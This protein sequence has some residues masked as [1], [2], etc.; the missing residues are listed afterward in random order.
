VWAFVRTGGVWAQRGPKLTP[1][2]ESG[3]GRF[4]GAVAVSANGDTLLVGGHGDAG[5]R[6]AAWAFVAAAG[7]WTQQGP[8]LIAP[9]ETPDGQFGG[10]VALSAAGTTAVISAWN[11]AGGAGTAWVYVRTGQAWAAAARLTPRD[12]TGPGAF[13]A[14][15]AISADGGIVL[16]GGPQDKGGVGGAWLF[17]R[18]GTE[19]QQVAP[20]LRPAGETGTGAFGLSVAL[21][22]D[23]ATA[24][25]GAG[26]DDQG[27]G[28][29]WIFA[30]AGTG[31]TQ[32]VSKL[33]A[34]DAL[35]A[36]A[37]GSAAALSADAT[38][39]LLGGPGDSQYA[40]AAWIY[41]DQYTP[42]ARG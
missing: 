40:G 24:L 5:G 41:A 32:E 12:E 1:S 16:I 4:G 23:G 14:G 10:R 18:F 2:D 42:L 35:G 39:A 34:G 38:T 37:L 27:G 33:A 17:G 31:W 11:D 36:A 6:G 26:G 21:S 28:A 19:W 30:R 22:A 15:V 29:A 9:D 25:V 20:K 8:K 7:G 13:G 3:S